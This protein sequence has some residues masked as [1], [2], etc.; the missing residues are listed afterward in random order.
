MW[1]YYVCAR[2]HPH[3]HTTT[4]AAGLTS[5]GWKTVGRTQQ[6]KTINNNGLKS[7]I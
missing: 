2:T 4:Q 7:A 1:A 5:Q 3:T 6:P